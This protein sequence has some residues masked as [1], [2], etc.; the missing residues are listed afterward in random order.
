MQNPEIKKTAFGLE[1]NIPWEEMQELNPGCKFC[2]HCRREIVD[3]SAYTRKEVELLF[4]GNANVCGVFDVGQ[5]AYEVKLPSFRF[6]AGILI[7]IWLLSEPSEAIGKEV[8]IEM[9]DMVYKRN[10]IARQEFASEK[11]TIAPTETRLRIF[12][13]KLY[14]SKRFPFIHFRRNRTM[15]IMRH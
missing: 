7:P 14:V 8:K 3:Y 1:C 4:A 2:A 5:F 6:L 15:G 12:R 9:T 11:T 10:P 13:R